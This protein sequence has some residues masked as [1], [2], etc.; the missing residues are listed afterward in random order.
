MQCHVGAFLTSIQCLLLQVEIC[1]AEH[2]VSGFAEAKRASN[3]FAVDPGIRRQLASCFELLPL[4]K[5]K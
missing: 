2:V 1:Q 3:N 4:S 5:K